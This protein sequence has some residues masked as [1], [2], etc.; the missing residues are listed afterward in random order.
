M[1]YQV[2]QGDILIEEVENPTE[3][4]LDRMDKTPPLDAGAVVTLLEGE[5]TGH[6]HQVE[7]RKEGEQAVLFEMNGKRYIRVPPGGADLIHPEH[8][9]IPFDKP[10]VFE[11]TRQT[12]FSG[13]RGGER[14]YVQD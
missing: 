3:P 5:A 6:A 14:L 11:I 9:T 13:E 12:I 4:F 2:R 1:S 8:G 7:A 10:G